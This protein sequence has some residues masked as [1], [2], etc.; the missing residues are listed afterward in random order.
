M[1]HQMFEKLT[2]CYPDACMVKKMPSIVDSTWKYC[3]P[4]PTH[5]F[6]SSLQRV[7]YKLLTLLCSSYVI[8]VLLL[9]ETNPR[10]R[11]HIQKKSSFTPHSVR[12][13]SFLY[14][15]LMN[16]LVPFTDNALEFKT[17]E[18]EKSTGSL[19]ILIG[20]GGFGQVFKGNF[21]HFHVGVKLL[22]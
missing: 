4:T 1:F 15:L 9:V 13:I 14:H 7:S 12:K 22:N 11:H 17:S 6:I 20:K 21:Q 16:L 19:S 3:I 8:Q 10:I 18:L 5:V 2:P